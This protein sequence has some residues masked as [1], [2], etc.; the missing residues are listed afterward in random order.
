[1]EDIFMFQEITR[2]YIKAL[3]SLDYHKISEIA[4]IMLDTYGSTGR[5]FICGNGGSASIA[6]HFSNDL[7]T[8]T[9]PKKQFHAIP[10]TTNISLMTTIS[11]DI[12]YDEIFAE[13]LRIH[14][15]N[16][17]DILIAI[18]SK[19]NSRNIIKAVEYAKEKGATTIGFTGST[20]GML[21]KIAG[22]CI[23]IDDN[24]YIIIEPVHSFICHSIA[25]YLKIKFSS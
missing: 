7:V 3:N 8:Y 17:R 25:E 2:R 1:M 14:N 10:L 24:D 13:Q 18:S 23:V 4:D 11:N 6:S 22:Y 16:E 20:G 21:K 5:I 9:K 15:V 19:G 12:S